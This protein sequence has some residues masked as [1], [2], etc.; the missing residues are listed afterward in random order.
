MAQ[1]FYMKGTSGVWFGQ[2]YHWFWATE[3]ILE[4]THPHRLPVMFVSTSKDNSG[5][6]KNPEIYADTATV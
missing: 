1:S 6:E 4:M 5:G 2:G 3:I